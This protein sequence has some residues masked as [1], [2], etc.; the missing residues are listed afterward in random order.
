[1]KYLFKAKDLKTGNWVTGDLAYANSDGLQILLKFIKIS[2]LAVA[3]HGTPEAVIKNI[4]TA[5]SKNM[6]NDLKAE[7]ILRKNASQSEISLARERIM[8][9]VKGLM[10]E[11]R[12]YIEKPNSDSIY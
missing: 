1:M 12:L 4:A 5:M 8:V 6:F 10:R 2:D 11:N 7:V 3:L 9:E